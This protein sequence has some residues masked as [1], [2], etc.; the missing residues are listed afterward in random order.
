MTN[1]RDAMPICLALLMVLAAAACSRRDE[2][3][4]SLAPDT[5]LV[6]PA[7]ANTDSAPGSVTTGSK[8]GST[9]APA[10]RTPASATPSAPRS[11]E[12]PAR[13]P[14]TTPIKRMPVDTFGLTR[15]TL[16]RKRPPE[17]RLPPPDFKP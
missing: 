13:H 8:A 14:E 1:T 10:T 12:Q 16:I 15:D 7:A 17:Q 5:S 3:A 9:P 2:P 6:V 4:D 11:A